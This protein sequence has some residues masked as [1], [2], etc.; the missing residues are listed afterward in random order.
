[1]SHKEQSLIK[2]YRRVAYEEQR[3]KC[4]W[5]GEKM[6]YKTRQNRETVWDDPR[7]CTAD[8]L[9]RKIDGGQTSRANIVAACRECNNRRVGSVP[10]LDGEE[11]D[12]LGKRATRTK[13]PDASVQGED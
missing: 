10:E 1:M 12:R 9:T 6:I 11:Y 5:C 8:H 7:V 2:R 3:G 4:Y 13:E